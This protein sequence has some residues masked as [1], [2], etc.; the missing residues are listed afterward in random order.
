M[1]TSMENAVRCNYCMQVFQENEIVYDKEH[2]VEVYALNSEVTESS[3]D[4]LNFVP[5]V[6]DTP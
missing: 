3:L 2:G 6:L 4:I 1:G 5:V